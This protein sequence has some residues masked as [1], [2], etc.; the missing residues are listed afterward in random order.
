MK[1]NYR[2]IILCFLVFGC[3][4]HAG[5]QNQMLRYADGQVELG[6]FHHAA[7]IYAQAFG[8]KETYHSAKG[9]AQSFDKLKDYSNSHKWWEKVVEFPG[10][11][12]MEDMESYLVSSYVVGQEEVAKEKLA[13]LGYA[14]ED[15]EQSKV[16]MILA[17]HSASSRLELEYLSDLNSSTA[18]DFTGAKDG[19]GNF[20]FVSDREE[21]ID[22]KPM[23]LIRFDAKNKIFNKNIYDWTG[24]EYLK[25]YKR[26][27]N[28]NIGEVKVERDDFLHISDPAIAM[29]DGSEYMFFTATRNV[30]KVKKQKSHTVHP[31]LFFGKLIDGEI[32]DIQDFP[33]NNIYGHSIITPFVDSGSNRLYF[34]SDMEGGFG[35]FDI[36]FVEFDGDLSFSNPNNLGDLVNSPG[37]ERDPFLFEERFYFSSDGNEGFGGFDI[38]QADS[39]GDGMLF[40]LSNLGAPINSIKDDF[41]YRKFDKDE[42]YLSSNRLG[43]TGLDNIYKLALEFRQLLVRVVDCDGELVKDYDLQVVGN[44]GN[45]LDMIPNDKGEYIGDLEAETDYLLN[46]AKGGHFSVEDRSI[47]TTD[48]EPGIIERNYRL[49]RIPSDMLV[50][51]DIIYYNLDKSDIR[52]DADQIIA[53]VHSLMEKYKFLD[54]KVS[55]HT[56]SR[57]S[58]EYNEALSKRRAE[59]V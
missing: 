24:R 48:M 39:K 54:L 9:A 43:D 57:A 36:Y 15:F 33:Y 16:D 49:I 7:E 19:D 1:K 22:S 31:E 53:K 29:I 10:E 5:A 3:L 55:S 40:N 52:R 58:H 11:S 35:G 6:N 23:P 4:H 51:T 30:P 45:K 42:I 56:D 41:G 27:S 21:I 37:N 18:A 38:F 50:Y 59:A 17:S 2:I 25:I 28:N 47:T 8:K 32:V 46:L 44:Q 20:Y 34:S 12:T 26:D 14:V 13:S